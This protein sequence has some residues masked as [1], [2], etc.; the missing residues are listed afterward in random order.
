MRKVYF[1]IFLIAVGMMAGCLGKKVN[2]E[3]TPI[4]GNT[5]VLE[6]STPIRFVIGLSI[7]GKDVPISFSRRSKA[8]WIEGL[9]PGEHHFD[10]KS[11]SYVFGPGFDR[12]KVS[13]QE[14]SYF[15][16]QERKY[17]MAL[18]KS[19]SEV[20][21]RAYRR[22]LKKKRKEQKKNDLAQGKVTTQSVR[23]EFR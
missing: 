2:P 4:P 19:R 17:R 10:I 11:L 16:I 6:F 7:D 5:L 20:S 23:A 18:P 1:P 12:F 13:E 21:I 8:L 14:G 22:E 15:F 3:K 9:T